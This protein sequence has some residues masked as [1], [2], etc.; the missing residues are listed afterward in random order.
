MKRSMAIAFAY[1]LFAIPIAT[2]VFTTVGLSLS[3]GMS[4]LAMTASSV[5]VLQSSLALHFALRR[6]TRHDS[7]L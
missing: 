4:A 6:L 2:G 3:P 1:N 7:V 5:A